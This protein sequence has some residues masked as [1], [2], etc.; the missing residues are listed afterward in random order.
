MEKVEYWRLYMLCVQ[1]HHASLT[2]T[3]YMY[4]VKC[5]IHKLRCG[6]TVAFAPETRARA[7]C[8]PL[9]LPPRSG[10][11]ADG[12]AR[13]DGRSACGQRPVQRASLSLCKVSVSTQLFEKRDLLRSSISLAHCVSG[14]VLFGPWP[15]AA[16]RPP[17]R[18]PPAPALCPEKLSELIQGP[19]K[20]LHVLAPKH[21]A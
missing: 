10:R 6:F 15:A 8:V 11:S 7:S 1:M 21:V 20:R 2:G 18:R 13:G 16:A 9:R 3:Q 14:Y 4:S 12:P 17:A 19:R 5:E